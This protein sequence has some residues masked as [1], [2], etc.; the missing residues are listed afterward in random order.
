MKFLILRS[1]LL[2]ALSVTAYAQTGEPAEL[3]LR[4]EHYNI[5]LKLNNDGTSEETRSWALKILDKRAIETAKSKEV[6]YST[7]IEKVEVL[8]AYTR[9]A[10][11]RRL[12][13]PKSNYQLEVNGGKDTNAPVFSDVTTLTVVFPEVE[14]GDTVVFTYKRTDIEPMFPGQFSDVEVFSSGVAYD[15]VHVTVDYPSA[16]PLQY[17]GRGLVQQVSEKD[18]RKIVD[19]TYSSKVPLRNKRVDYSV[20][21]IE[22]EPGYSVS[23]FKSYADIAL[24][25][26]LRAKPK[27]AVTPRVQKLADD[28]ANG[29]PTPREQAR[30]EYEWVAKNITY[31]G[32]CIGVGAVVPHD[33]DFILDNKMGDC[34]DHATLLEALLRA[35]GIASVQALVNASSAY[36]LAKIP[37]V[38]MVNHVINYLP[39][40]D[41]FVD[42]TASDQPFGILSMSV[43]GKP[44]LLV[45]GYKDGV[46]TPVPPPGANR[47]HTNT[48][49]TI[50]TDGS[51]KGEVDVT[52][53]GRFGI[54]SRAGFRNLGQQQQQELV[55]NVLKGQ[56]HIGDGVFTKDDPTELTDSYHYR[57]KFDARD[58]VPRPGA[59]A[60]GIGPVLFSEAP[61][62]GFARAAFEP[63]DTVDFFCSDATITE[64]YVFHFPKNM[65]ILSVPENAAI[66]EQFVTYR[67]SYKL[68][69]S[70][71]T[72]KRELLD[73]TP[74]NVCAPA[75]SELYKR[76]AVKMAQDLK[77]QVVFK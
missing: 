28:I 42:S 24:A 69:G 4:F 62:T 73:K 9:K 60:F 70:T 1:L 76:I 57:A 66:T 26:G 77:A 25:Y 20:F 33:I 31:A 39:D 71:L 59:G 48:D 44:V 46:K 13:V 47:V 35:K 45:D 74:G 21:D 27:T 40:F 54:Q 34:K 49:V 17:E 58:F 67:S 5:G 15:D 11:G 41:L 63:V 32:N 61:L 37:V 10:D 65:K 29:K 38:S 30:A 2:L 68:K 6:S 75:V 19:W 36:H 56:G 14:V 72:V 50:N 18:G 53:G 23:T 3:Y 7:S 64:D 51:I 43:A 12:D 55:K 22:K 16:L 8:E 52:L